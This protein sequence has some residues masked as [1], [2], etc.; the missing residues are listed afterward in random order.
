MQIEYIGFTSFIVLY[1]LLIL[2]LG[3]RARGDVD[4]DQVAEWSAAGRSFGAVLLWFLIGASGISAYT[5]LG[6]PGWAYSRGVALLYVTAYLSLMA[7]TGYLV[8]PYA[9]TLGARVGEVTMPGYIAVRFESIP[10]GGFVAFSTAIGLLGYAVLQAIGAGYIIN[11]ATGGIV[12][13]PLAVLL[14]LGIMAIYIYTSGMRAIGWTN[15]IQSMLMLFVAYLATWLLLYTFYPTTLHGGLFTDLAANHPEFL[16]L[17]GALEDMPPMFWATSILVSVVSVWPSTWLFWSSA[18]TQDTVRKAQ[19]FLPLYYLL[20]PLGTFMIGLLGII[21][22]PGVEPVD[23]IGV[24]M[25]IEYAPLLIAGLYLAGTAAAAMSSAEPMYLTVASMWTEYILSPILDWSEE[26]E[27]KYQRLLIFPLLAIVGIVAYIEPATLVYILLIGYGFIAQSWTAVMGALWW[28]RA[29]S[30]A[31]IIGIIVG[32]IVTAL[33]SFDWL[34][35]A[36][37]YGVH[38]GIWGLI[39]NTLIFVVGSFFTK[40]AS[41]E[42]LINFF[43]ELRDEF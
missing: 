32:S 24:E 31:C 11:L 34:I 21:Y 6:A 25:M 26:Q 1:M 3:V 40:P 2:W 9:R 29:T 5:F 33:L 28:P 23:Q 20:I 41:R 15:L 7:Y 43:P 38:G 19:T 14:V 36:H 30:T 42:T 22:L 35:W 16:T 37:P 17:P 39:V 10:L 8:G 13:Y 18:G 12:S 4:M 27:G